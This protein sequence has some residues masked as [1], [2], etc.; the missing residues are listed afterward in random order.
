MSMIVLSG[1]ITAI[2]GG[3]AL[4]ISRYERFGFMF[5]GD[6]ADD[7]GEL[8]MQVA[9]DDPPTE[10]VTLKAT[11]GSDISTS[12]ATSIYFI[13]IGRWLRAAIVG[14]SGS[15]TCDYAVYH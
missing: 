14:G 6:G 13:A 3:D 4:D 10:W 7:G 9:V 11:D 2:G 5:Q 12:T 1:R 8:A 15:P